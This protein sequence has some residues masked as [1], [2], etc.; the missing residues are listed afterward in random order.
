MNVLIVGY[1]GFIGQNL[2]YK[3]KE[4]KKFKILLL[5]KNSSQLEIEHKVCAAQ[6][7]FL[8]FGVNREKLPNYT[9]KDNYLLTEN[10]CSILLRNRKKTKIIFTSSIQINQNNSYG[11]SKLRAEKILL[12]YKKKA[13]ASIIIYRLPNIFGK[14]S[15]PFYNS[16]VAT[17]CFNIVRNQRIFIS[18]NKKMLRLFYIDDL[19]KNFISKITLKK[20]KTYV[21]I[22]NTYN[23]SLFK[24]A[25]LIKSF[26]PK[27]NTLLPNDVSKDFVKKLFS[28]YVSFLPSSKFKYKIKSNSDNRGAF[29]EF[30]KNDQFGQF[31]Y[32]S[33][34]PKKIRGNHFHHTKIEKFIVVTGKAK[35][36]FVNIINKKK[37]SI[38]V[39]SND[40]LVINSIPG[41]AHNIENPGK[42][43]TKILVWCNEILSKKNP[44]TNFYKI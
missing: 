34:L 10:I 11:K 20:W 22:K 44:D 39:S 15:R 28:T 38:L 5:E 32:F 29:V 19:I 26:N 27:D 41:W 1:K 18:K 23:I 43:I 37:N 12:E 31:S 8:I 21:E 3:L 2:F 13:K 9:F 14:W 4:N 24:L 42:S 17:Y 7:I 40:N 30:L 6:L 35:F 36:N 25:N 16:V 33:I